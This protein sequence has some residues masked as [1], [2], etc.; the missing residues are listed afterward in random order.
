M[1]KLNRLSLFSLVMITVG[2]VDSVRNLPATAL[3]GSQLIFFFLLGAVTFLLPCALVSAE[4]ASAYPC[5]GGIYI[6]VREAFGKQV[7]LVAI[8]FQWIENVIWYPTIL[9]FVAGTLGYLISASLAQNKLF[10]FLTILVA[11]WGATYI[12]SRGMQSSAWF[13]NICAV[14]GLLIPMALI[15]FL[16]AVWY[17]GGRPTQIHFQLHNLLPGAQQENVWV[18]LTGVILSFCGIEIAT[19]HA[20]DVEN[21]QKTF[22]R[23]LL[24]SVIIIVT[25]L[26]MGSLAIAVVL[27]AH[28]ISLVAGIMQ[29][30]DVFLAAYHLPTWVHSVFAGMLV[31]GGLGAV[32][33]WIIS[34]T[35][36]LLVAAQEGSLPP[37]L[38]TTNAQGAPTV[39]LLYQA[40]FVTILA[41]VFLAMDSVNES[42]WLLTALAA[43]TYMFMYLL[44]FAAGIYLR[45][46]RPT[47]A[48]AFQIPGGR[49]GMIIVAGLGM[50]AAFTTILVGFMPPLNTISSWHYEVYL[51]T[52]LVLLSLPPFIAVRLQRPQWVVSAE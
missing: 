27:P 2:S 41:L 31:L 14:C 6:W 44:M 48:G 7:A 13:S 36:G 1:S 28:Q 47:Q 16:G 5:Q 52:G 39:L 51:C 20:S 23:A 35:K 40:V 3:F 9:A 29:A 12:N 24:Y 18:A 21:P 11:F 49:W 32:S 45:L 46:T 25:T 22:P 43:Q 30:F 8:W 26:I 19:V 10:L 38:Q 42:Y 15:I 4:L 37:Q 17:F 50:V 34:P 33:N